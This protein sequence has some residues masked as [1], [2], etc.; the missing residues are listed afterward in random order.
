MDRLDFTSE[1]SLQVSDREARNTLFPPSSRVQLVR[2]SLGS[3]SRSPSDEKIKMGWDFRH[4][5]GNRFFK[6]L[7]WLEFKANSRDRLTLISTFTN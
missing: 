5:L 4:P 1:E 6:L 2:K 7:S 3:C